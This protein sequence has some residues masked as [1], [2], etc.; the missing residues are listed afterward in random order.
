MFWILV[1]QEPT[2]STEGV[3]IGCLAIFFSLHFLLLSLEHG[4]I[5]PEILSQRDI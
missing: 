2:V 5:Q 4:L 3:G 1:G